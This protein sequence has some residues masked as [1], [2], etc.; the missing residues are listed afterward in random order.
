MPIK[1][2]SVVS[3]RGDS[4]VKLFAYFRCVSGKSGSETQK[5][6]KNSCLGIT[7]YSLWETVVWLDA[8]SRLA[9]GDRR[10]VAGANLTREEY[11]GARFSCPLLICSFLEGVRDWFSLYCKCSS[12]GYVEC[13]STEQIRLY[14]VLTHTDVVDYFRCARL[15][16]AI[17]SSWASDLGGVWFPSVNFTVR[18]IKYLNTC[19]QYMLKFTNLN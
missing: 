5:V 15:F 13:F 19:I 14:W 16:A 2:M 9:P 3:F 1:S 6:R 11:S 12:A 10:S 4:Q 7:M 8:R 17:C 18:H